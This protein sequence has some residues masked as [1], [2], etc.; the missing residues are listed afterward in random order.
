MQSSMANMISKNFVSQLTPGPDF[1][2]QWY[3]IVREYSECG[4]T[5]EREIFPA[6]SGIAKKAASLWYGSLSCWHMV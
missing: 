4:L 6:L 1:P 3:R 2:L 5:Y